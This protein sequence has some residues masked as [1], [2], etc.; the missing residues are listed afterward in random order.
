[1]GVLSAA[2]V[3]VST[4]RMVVDWCVAC[5][6]ANRREKSDTAVFSFVLEG[7]VPWR[8]EERRAP[9][10]PMLEVYR[11]ERLRPKGP[12]SSGC[13]GFLEVLGDLVSRCA[14]EGWTAER[15]EL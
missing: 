15:V 4:G 14:W 11:I 2:G 3:S 1:M 13:L 9:L 12:V 8:V 5:S 7:V 6:F 10:P